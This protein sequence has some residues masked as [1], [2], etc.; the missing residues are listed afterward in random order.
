MSLPQNTAPPFSGMVY[1]YV[2]PVQGPTNNITTSTHSSVPV[3]QPMFTANGPVS[4]GGPVPQWATQRSPE[5][6]GLSDTMSELAISDCAQPPPSKIR[7]RNA[8]TIQDPDPTIFQVFYWYND[9][10]YFD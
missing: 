1:P 4:F 8:I 2:A 5:L 9:L 3:L 10:H 7:R 6:T